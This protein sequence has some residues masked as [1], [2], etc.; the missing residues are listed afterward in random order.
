[1]AIKL[2]VWGD[3]ALFTRPEMKVERVSYDI[4]TPSAARG[5]L[6]AIY[7]HPGMKWIVDRIY[8]CNPIRFTNLRRNEVKSTISARNV[9]GIMEKGSGRTYI[10]TAESIQQRASM[11]LRDVRYVIDAHFNMTDKA[12]PEDNPGKFQD[13]MKRRIEKGQCYHT[14]YLGTRECPASFSLCKLL[15]DISEELKGERDLGYMLWD[16]EYISQ[17]DIRPLFFRA[18]MKNGIVNIPTRDSGE[19]LG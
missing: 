3:Y 14:P 12:C 16:M 11:L 6:E 9:N 17:E 13:I 4:M 2:E 7:W 10:S 1:M 8:V 5:I 18:V 19:V 15:P